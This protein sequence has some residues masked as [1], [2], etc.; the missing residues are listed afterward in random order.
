[1]V[2]PKKLKKLEKI[3]EVFVNNFLEQSNVYY[4]DN[5]KNNLLSTHYLVVKDYTLIMDY[6]DIENKDRLQIY[7]NNKLISK[8]H[9][10]DDFL[11]TLNT[12]SINNYNLVNNTNVINF[13]Y[14]LWHA[15]L[16]HFNNNKNIQDF[17]LKAYKL[18]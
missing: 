6:D 1:M 10:N 12:Q 2:N 8:I 4:A 17:V 13:D 18:T 16:G 7:K 14:D 11:F 15:R 9:A 5:I 3:I